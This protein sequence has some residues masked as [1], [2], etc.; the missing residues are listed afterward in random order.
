MR[1]RRAKTGATDGSWV[2]DL[3]LDVIPGLMV[4]RGLVA[5][6]GVLVAKPPPW[7]SGLRGCRH[8]GAEALKGAVG[9]ECADSSWRPVDHSRLSDLVCKQLGLEHPD[10]YGYGTADFRDVAVAV[11]GHGAV[12]FIADQAVAVAEAEPFDGARVG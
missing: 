9:G 5:M 2:I 11:P 12:G 8:G 3:G 4:R 7:R 10:A 1:E 6:L